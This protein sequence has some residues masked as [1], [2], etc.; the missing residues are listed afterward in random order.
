MKTNRSTLMAVG[1]GIAALGLLAAVPTL[2]GHRLAPAFSA[3][4]GGSREWL[5]LAA[6]GFVAAFVCTVGAWRAAFF[7]AGARVCPRDTA[8]RLG[9]GSLVNAF[10][11]AKLG[12]AV[13]VTLCG[14]ALDGP[15]GMWT[16]GG[17]YAALAA[18]RSLAL[19]SLVVAASVTGAI[20]LWPV[21]GL[22]GLVAAIAF[23]AAFS[24][25]LR[26]HARI[27][28]L[29]EGTAALARSPR[30]AAVVIG[31]SL[32]VQLSRLFAV[33]AIT[34]ALGVPHALFA[35]LLISCALDLSGIFPL[36]PGAI[37][38]GSAAVAAALASRGIGMTQALGV[39]ISIQALE[40]LVSIGIGCLGAAYL[41]RANPVVRLWTGRVAIVGGS[42]ALA[43]GVGMLLLNLS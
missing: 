8:A 18:A 38:V 13:K 43:A 36:T 41:T 32:G 12:D 6:A 28:R 37:G 23:T 10:A 9:I 35:A 7:A 15:G 26:G 16:S 2:L 25:R 11:P 42:A 19:A 20:P 22:C 33:A 24:R 40:T 39:G 34:A 4:G 14:R 1:A 31:W 17:V 3:L 21:F 5:A 30:N 29:L 27:S